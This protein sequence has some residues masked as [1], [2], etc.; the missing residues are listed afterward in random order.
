MRLLRGGAIG[1]RIRVKA[2]L[3][4][5]A[6]RDSQ[7]LHRWL[8]Y[9]SALGFLPMII[10]LGL[11]YFVL[12]MPVSAFYIAAGLWVAWAVFVFVHGMSASL[13]L[14]RAH[15]AYM[16]AVGVDARLSSVL[17]DADLWRKSV[18]GMTMRE[19]IADRRTVPPWRPN[20]E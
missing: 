10:V 6:R 17:G 3:L 20:A 5:S 19:F 1:R 18:V 8:K 7:A 14:N 4:S 11:G 9:V 13:R 12:P 2:V 15:D 16:R